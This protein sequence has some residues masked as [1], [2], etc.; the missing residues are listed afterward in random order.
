MRWRRQNSPLTSHQ[1]SL[2]ALNLDTSLASIDEK[3]AEDDEAAGSP[4][5]LWLSEE[6][7]VVDDE[8]EAAAVV[9]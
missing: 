3:P 4:S 2:I 5:R 1:L 9:L 7:E 8:V 6:E